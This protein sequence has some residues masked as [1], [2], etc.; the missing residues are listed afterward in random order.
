MW[1]WINGSKQAE[2]PAFYHEKGFPHP[3]N[4]PG[5]R[6]AGCLWEDHNGALWLFGGYGYAP[7]GEKGIFPSIHT[8]IL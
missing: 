5:S 7:N 2:Q 4:I 3:D 8:F 6:S 1:T